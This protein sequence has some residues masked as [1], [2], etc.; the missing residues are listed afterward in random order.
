M[1]LVVALGNTTNKAYVNSVGALAGGIQTYNISVYDN[2][3]SNFT[4]ALQGATAELP[5]SL[6]VYGSEYLKGSEAAGNSV[7]ASFTPYSNQP[8]ILRDKY[9]VNGSD[10]AQIGWVEVTTEIGTGGYLWY[11]KSEH[12]AR[13][14]FEDYLEMAMVEAEKAAGT[15]TAN[16]G[17]NPGGGNI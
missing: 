14:R 10:V 11:L 6:F 1:T 5:L 16:V 12:E 17:Q 4:A 15:I 7:D 2:A 13:I 3:N 8:I 9:T